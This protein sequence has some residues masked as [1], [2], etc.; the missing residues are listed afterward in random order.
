MNRRSSGGV[1]I[2]WCKLYCA[3]PVHTVLFTAET[4][5]CRLLAMTAL[6]APAS[7]LVCCSYQY[8]EAAGG[9]ALTSSR[10][11]LRVA[12]SCSR[13]ASSSKLG[14]H[15]GG[16]ESVQEAQQY[17][18]LRYSVWFVFNC[19]GGVFHCCQCGKNFPR[20]VRGPSRIS[21]GQQRH[22]HHHHR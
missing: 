21:S 15:Q 9:P 19:Y 4:T 12:M 16:V 20:P 14:R 22:H 11:C 18:R 5:G 13:V 6:D 1:R 17:P 10:P 3:R 7:P 2:A 8:Q